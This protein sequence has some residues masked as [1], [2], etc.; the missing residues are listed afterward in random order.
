[1]SEPWIRSSTLPSLYSHPEQNQISLSSS[2]SPSSHSNSNILTLPQMLERYSSIYN[3]NGRIGI[4]TREE[5]DAIISRFHEKRKKRVWIKKIRYH[6][7]KNLADN[8]IRIKGRFVRHIETDI[9][10]NHHE[11]DGHEN[12]QN[13]SISTSPTITHSKNTKKPF[14]S[15]DLHPLL[16]ISERKLHEQKEDLESNNSGKTSNSSKSESLR[17][18]KHKLQ[19]NNNNSNNFNDDNMNYQSDHN[20]DKIDSTITNSDHSSLI[21]PEEMTLVENVRSRKRMRRHSVAY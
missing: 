10:N 6:C 15:N 16:P 9:E 7:R 17:N 13:H 3:T 4:Y 18:K 19:N 12:D 20:D 14:M 5:R 2:S 11:S 21:S 1:M 8:R